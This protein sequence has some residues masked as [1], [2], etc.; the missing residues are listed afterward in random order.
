MM[1][2]SVECCECGKK[3]KFGDAKDVQFAKWRILAW[4]VKTAEPVVV[5]NECEYGK[6]KEKKK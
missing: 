2:W 5:C 1:A 4:N 6:P 3:D